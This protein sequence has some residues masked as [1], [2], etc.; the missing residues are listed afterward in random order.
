LIA[1]GL[2]PFDPDRAAIRAGRLMLTEIQSR[3]R[4]GS[5]FDISGR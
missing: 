2:S 3:V 4:N 1:A 5:S